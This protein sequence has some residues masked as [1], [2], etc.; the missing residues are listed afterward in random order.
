MAGEDA[1]LVVGADGMI[2]RCL[3]HRLRADGRNIVRTVLAPEPGAET[4]DLSQDVS[5]WT[6]PCPVTV[7]YLCAAATSL[8]RCRSHVEET[9]AIN[10]T[11]TLTLARTLNKQGA[12]VVFPSSNL[13]FDGSVPFQQPGAATCPRT[14]YGRQKA[15]VERYLRASP[16][17]CVVRFTKVLGP[18]T[19]LF[20]EWANALRAGRPIHPFAD[21]VMA[22]VP[23]DF[24][25]EVLAAVGRGR[26]EGVFQVSGPRDV[27][28]AEVAQYVASRLHAS[29]EFVQP[30][31]AAKSG[32][33]L[34][35]V[36]AH[37]TLDSTRLQQELGLAPPDVWAAVD[38]GMVLCAD[39]NV[40]ED[41]SSV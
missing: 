25:V 37:T 4:L 23:L 36:P 35:H 9:R 16:G 27:S 34:E 6:P 8:A 11:A 22:P 33:D 5:G 18:E 41:S 32:V 31:T 21:M 15:E 29:P 40:S 14:E 10:V 26:K 12:L 13:V 2:G 7:V 28:Y 20:V 1:I 3:A 24:A 19:P 38:A 17:A 39:R 30:V